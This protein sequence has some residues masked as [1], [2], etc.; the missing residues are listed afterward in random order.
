MQGKSVPELAREMDMGLM[1][2][3]SL[4]ISNVLVFIGVAKSSKR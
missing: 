1:C 4:V 2:D 3:G